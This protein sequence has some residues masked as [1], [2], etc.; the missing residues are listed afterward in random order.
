[1][2]V[3]AAIWVI[4]GRL[5]SE[6]GSFSRV[7]EEPDCTLTHVYRERM[8]QRSRR[9]DH[10]IDNEVLFSSSAAPHAKTP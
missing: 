7:S 9:S 4:V 2:Y 8:L 1:V 6:P 5:P 3:V 10:H